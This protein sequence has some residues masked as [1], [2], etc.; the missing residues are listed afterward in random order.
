MEIQEA[1]DK[2]N[3][4]NLKPGT[5]KFFHY[6]RILV[7]EEGANRMLAYVEGVED[8]INFKTSRA[9]ENKIVG[10][11][12]G[13]IFSYGL[14]IEDIK[15]AVRKGSDVRIFACE[16]HFRWS[17]RKMIERKFPKQ[18]GLILKDLDAY[19]K[20]MEEKTKTNPNLGDVLGEE[21]VNVLKEVVA[22]SAEPQP[23]SAP[24]A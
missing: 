18:H 10:W 1:I 12:R 4:S 19:K 8:N 24:S 7:N 22:A 14:K 6:L 9:V 20:K 17:F 23:E 5:E 15:I 13:I 21:N 2:I 11:V 3:L 16:R